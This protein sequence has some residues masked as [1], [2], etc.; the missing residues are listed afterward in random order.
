VGYFLKAYSETPFGLQFSFNTRNGPF[1]GTLPFV[2]GIFISNKQPQP[3]WFWWGIGLFALGSSLHLTEAYLLYRNWGTDPCHDYLFGTIFMG[4]GVTLISLSNHTLLRIPMAGKLGKL[5]LGIYASHFLFVDL[6]A[7]IDS[8]T[9]S[10]IWEIGYVFI[11]LFCSILFCLALS[12]TKYM[13]R[14][15]T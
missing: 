4:L 5:T 15:V 2:I 1:F 7:P 10:P 9:N 14:L 11:V 12:K 13:R 6:F 3:Q 8:Y